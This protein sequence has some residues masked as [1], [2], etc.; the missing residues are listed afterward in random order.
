MGP[1]LGEGETDG[2]ALPGPGSRLDDGDDDGDG[3]GDGGNGEADCDG[4]GPVEKESLLDPVPDGV[5][6][7]EEE[8]EEEGDQVA[9]AE[10]DPGRLGVADGV[11]AVDKVRDADGEGLGELVGEGDGVACTGTQGVGTTRRQGGHNSPQ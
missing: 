11:G 5:M 9:D 3:D 8:G 2:E 6:G 10:V 4:L 1:P 7:E